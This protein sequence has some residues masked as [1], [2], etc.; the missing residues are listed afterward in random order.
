MVVD[1]MVTVGFPGEGG[2][3][4]TVFGVAECVGDT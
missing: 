4:A 3:M 1:D 2:E